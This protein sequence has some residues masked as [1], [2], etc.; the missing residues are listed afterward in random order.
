MGIPANGG[1]AL[2][3]YAVGGVAFAAKIAAG[4]YASAPIAVGDSVHG[5]FMFDLDTGVSQEAVR[6]AIQTLYPKTRRVLIA[7]FVGAV[8]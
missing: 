5:Q 3:V 2:G 8:Q 4:G 6:Q 1:C 7:L